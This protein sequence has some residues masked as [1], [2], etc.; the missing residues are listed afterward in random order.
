MESKKILFAFFF[1]IL[2][3]VVVSS[4]SFIG[5]TPANNDMVAN[6][7]ILLNY[8]IENA[9]ANDAYF[10][11][12]SGNVGL[13]IF[14]GDYLSLTGIGLSEGKNNISVVMKINSSEYILDV[15]NLYYYPNFQIV[16]EFPTPSNNDIIN[17][18]NSIVLNSTVLN[19]DMSLIDDAYFVINSGNV[20][21]G[22]F[23]GYS[24]IAS[25]M[26]FVE[27]NNTIVAIYDINGKEFFGSNITF[28]IDT[29]APNLYLI[30]GNVTLTVGQ[31][32]NDAGATA[33]DSVSGDLTSNITNTTNINTGVPGT[34]FV[35]YTVSDNAGNTAS[36][37]RTITVNAAPVVTTGNGG[38]NGGSSVQTSCDDWSEC[39]SGTQT[40]ICT[41]G[42]TEY[43][44][45]RE[46]A[47][48]IDEETPAVD[49]VDGEDTN[50]PFF[51]TITGA[52]TGAFGQASTYWGILVLFIILGAL[53]FFIL[54]KRKSSK[55]KKKSKK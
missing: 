33:N 7:N 8:S 45:S 37:N 53:Y 44:K 30:D 10:L 49:I 38:G 19:I 46:C 1:L 13:G 17:S 51:S 24:L 16:Y 15:F 23:D 52:V 5:N 18:P 21:L 14:D 22:I 20:G 40:Q 11:I 28:T 12:N 54:K 4:G 6:Q 39:T 2:S 50:Q 34:Y 43:T 3:L 36:V 25:N 42:S 41:S 29:T 31:I 35:T 48:A 27:G 32:Y 9:S 55:G 47:V 26:G